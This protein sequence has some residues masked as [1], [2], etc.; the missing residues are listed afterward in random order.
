MKRR[1][2]AAIIVCLACVLALAGCSGASSSGS[3]GSSA[4]SQTLDSGAQAI[5]ADS[6]KGFWEIEP[7]SSLGFEAT[8]NLEDDGFAEF[9]YGD[10]YADG[11]W[12][13]DG[14][15]ASIEFP[16]KFGTE[17]KKNDQADD[18]VR[19]AVISLNGDKLV[20]GREDGSKLVFIKSDISEYYANDPNDDSIL[21]KDKPTETEENVD[22][23]DEV[24]EDMAP[25]S[26][27]D[28][29]ICAIEV[30]GKGTDYIADPGYRLSVK[31]KSDKTISLSVDGAFTVNGNEVEA[32]LLEFVDPDG[33][34][35]TFLS[36]PADQLQEGVEGLADV[37]GT[38]L[39][40][41]EMTSEKLGSYPVKIS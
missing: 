15:Q 26:I 36:F 7:D 21:M 1:Y 5:G 11:T 24:V 28:D 12:K 23:V 37:E 16:T 10:A 19:V 17:K 3:Q 25:V 4:G 6:I 18:G 27:S 20:M 14:T 13:V 22:I 38:I 35:E 8:L 40:S 2:V 32:N 39:V 29:E 9:V 33:S 31:N 34:V 30:T 41:D